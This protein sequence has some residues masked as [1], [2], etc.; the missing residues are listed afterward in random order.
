MRALTSVHALANCQPGTISSAVLLRSVSSAGDASLGKAMLFQNVDPSI[1]KALADE[2]EIT[3]V[4]RGAVLFAEGDVAEHFYVVLSGKVK[5]TYRSYDGRENLVELLG[6][7]DQFGEV[8]V[9]DSAPR[10]T[11]ATVI[12]DARIARL[13]ADTLHEW[14]SCHPQLATQLLRAISHRLRRTQADLSSIV[15]ADA[16]SRIAKELLR[17]A[18]RFGVPYGG[19]IRVEHDLSQSELAQLVNASRETVNKIL[20]K[21]ANR[22]WVRIEAKCV[23]ILDRERLAQ[24]AR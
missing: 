18:H 4:L 14:I 3:S 8:S 15:F 19:E 10:T 12:T 11:T 6:P 23:V 1:V 9:L 2:F 21:F 7:S 22:G 20:S 5:L 16:S 13:P 24:R 17:L